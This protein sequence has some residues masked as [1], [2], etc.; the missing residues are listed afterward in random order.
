VLWVLSVVQGWK[1]SGTIMMLCYTAMITIP[2]SLFEAAKLEGTNYF[3]D[4]RLII[5]PL[6]KPT[7]KLALSMMLLWSFKT[8]DIVWTM[9]RGGPGGLSLTAP[10]QMVRTAFT[11]NKYGYAAAIGM[12]LTVL[13][14]IC[15]V[16]GRR[17]AKGETYEY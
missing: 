12:V 10:I 3:Q 9:T 14:S 1:F 5:L 4:V 8:Y 7:I 13:V 11:F 17:L 16:L 2:G 15:I 6:I